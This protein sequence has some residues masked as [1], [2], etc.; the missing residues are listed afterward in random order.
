[1]LSILNS[2]GSFASSTLAAQGRNTMKE[3]KD[4]GD[5]QDQSNRHEKVELLLD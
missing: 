3:I 1:M 2:I 4:S 5:V